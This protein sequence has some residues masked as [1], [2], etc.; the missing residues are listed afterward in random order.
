MYNGIG[1]QINN[2]ILRHAADKIIIN[3]SQLNLLHWHNETGIV[4]EGGLVSQ[5]T[6]LTGNGLH[7]I[8]S[9]ATS[10][11]S[12]G[13]RLINGL[14]C[15]DF[16]GANDYMTMAS[17]YALGTGDFSIVMVFVADTIS[18]TIF[19]GQANATANRLIRASQTNLTVR[20]NATN[21]SMAVPFIETQVVVLTCVFNRNGDVNVYINGSYYD[22]RDISSNASYS[23]PNTYW[24]FGAANNDALFFDGAACEF[25]I[26]SGAMTSDEIKGTANF[27]RE[28]WGI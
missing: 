2:P 17:T 9:L 5:W 14:N 13:I 11:P 6:D 26:T 10:K 15:L 25:F 7:L 1:F 24:K 16:D 18:D 20:I 22:R 12:T 8:Q 19:W 4:S 27:L 23:I 21:V 28:K 3:P